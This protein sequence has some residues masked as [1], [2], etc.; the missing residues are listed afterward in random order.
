MRWLKKREII[1]YY[2]LFSRFSLC[3]FSLADAI[4]VLY[5]YFSK[6]VA[7]GIL[8][9]LTKIGLIQRSSSSYKLTDLRDFVLFDV[10][11]DYLKRRSTLRHK[12]Q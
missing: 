5:P 8:R 3:E 11:Y 9:Y 2:L 4:A 6:K 10:G 1:A 12:T 7:L